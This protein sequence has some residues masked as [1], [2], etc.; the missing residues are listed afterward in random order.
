MFDGHSSFF[1]HV[2]TLSDEATLRFTVISDGIS[3]TLPSF[4]DCESERGHQVLKVEL[5][6]GVRLGFSIRY[7]SS[8]L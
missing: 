8:I 7:R 5:G 1:K 4:F 2:R 6:I 3:L